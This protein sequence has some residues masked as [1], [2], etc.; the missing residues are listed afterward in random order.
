MQYLSL[1][2]LLL[3]IIGV[4]IL[5]RDELTSLAAIIKQN[6]STLSGSLWQKGA[7][8]LANKFGSSDPLD[9]ESFIGESFSTRFLGI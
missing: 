2:G 8:F 1:I 4:G 5:I 3:D 7:Y 6:N 9:T